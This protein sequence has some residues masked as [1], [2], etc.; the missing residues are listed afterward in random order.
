L[1]TGDRFPGV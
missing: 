1:A